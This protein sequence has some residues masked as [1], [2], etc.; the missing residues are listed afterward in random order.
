M[1]CKLCKGEVDVTFLNKVLG[2]YVKDSKNK[3][4]IVCKS[5]QSSKTMEEIKKNV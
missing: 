1:K 5:C 3:K 4:Q 2:T